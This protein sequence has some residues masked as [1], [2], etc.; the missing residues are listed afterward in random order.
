MRRR[1]RV[2]IGFR[3]VMAVTGIVNG[4][5]SFASDVSQV[6]AIER[7]GHGRSTYNSKSAQASTCPVKG[8]VVERIGG[9]GAT[10]SSRQ[11]VGCPAGETNGPT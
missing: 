11:P 8:N 1:N 7:I 5:S 9:G 6:A 4:A 2:A 3:V 10:Y